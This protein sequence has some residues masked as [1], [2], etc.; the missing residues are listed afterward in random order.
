TGEFLRL[1]NIEDILALCIE[2]IKAERSTLED[3]LGQH[4]S[5]RRQLEPLLRIALSIKESPPF[6]PTSD[7]RVRAR[8]HLMNYIH[9]KRNENR[10]WKDVFNSDV[11]QCWYSGW[12]KTVAIIV[13]VILAFSALGTGTAYA[14]KDSLPGETLYSVKIGTEQIRRLLTVNDIAQIEL[15]LTFADI[16]LKEIEA[17]AHKNPTMITLATTGYEENTAKAIDKAE[18]CKDRGICA[19]NLEMVALTTSKHISLLDM[20]IDSV[21]KTN[22]EFARQAEEV[23][24]RA[25]FRA[26]RAL[27]A[28]DPV[29]AIHRNVENMQNRLNRA[30]DKADEGEFIEVEESLRQFKEMHKFGEELS[31][32]VKDSG[33]F[34]T[35]ID[36]INAQARAAQMEALS[37]MSGKVSKETLA[38]V[39]EVMGISVENRGKEDTG[40]PQK[41]AD[42]IPQKPDNYSEET[43]NKPE[44]PGNIAD[45]TGNGSGE[46]GDGS[47][48]PGDGFGQSGGGSGE[49]GGGSGESG[50]G[51]GESGGGS[52]ESGGGSG[53]SG[54]GSGES[55]GGSGE[56]G[57]GSGEPGGGSGEPGNSSGE[58]GEGSGEP[59]DGSGEPGDGSGE[60][61]DG[62]SEPDGGSGEP[63]SG[64]GEPN[65]GSGEPNDGSG[66]PND[67]SGEPGGGPQ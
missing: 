11:R 50:S 28:E 65:G 57:D 44:E 66:E 22:K 15:E 3:C 47:G 54:G 12:L 7:F 19:E 29:R 21:T 20:I 63:N 45:E 31:Q 30:N 59:G 49:S 41:G 6:K 26:L 18:I 33:Y 9:D 58:P 1:K 64:S 48:E 2:D 35:V 17:L 55:G 16:R 34:P 24:F 4:S 27:A 60:P 5:V 13:A 40:P 56:P 14:S 53:E 32:I 36:A 10:S 61:G 37:K 52:G 43:N 39:K 25:Q 8:V 42:N 67:G 38:T 23:A 62:S 46:P 51:S